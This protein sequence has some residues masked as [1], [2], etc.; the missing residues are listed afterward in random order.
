MF[1]TIAAVLGGTAHADK[2][3]AK[4]VDGK[5]IQEGVGLELGVIV[6]A[7][8]SEY[9]SNNLGIAPNVQGLVI[10][11]RNGV[12]SRMAIGLLVAIA[13]AM[14]QSGPKSVESK[15]YRSGDYIITETKTTYYSEAEKAEMAR[16]TEKSIDGLFSAPYADF[17]LHLYSRDRF[18]RGDTSGYK[19]NM[20]IGSG[21]T[22]AF[23]TGL[24]FG[25][26]TSLVE[27]DGMPTRVR[28]SYLGMPFRVSA[29]AG[30]VRIALTYEWNWLDYGVEG[31]DRQ[32]GMDMDGVAATRTTSHPWHLDMSTLLFKRISLTGGVTTQVLRKYELGFYATAGLF[33]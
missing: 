11:D 6:Q 21:D 32:L 25:G 16:N 12:T 27:H 15:S 9:A 17:E 13:G 3:R 7:G 8:Q 19:L 4:L 28:Y 18:G 29:A 1:L 22:Y 2:K 30:P 10:R 24:G 26:V 20:L 5:A 23:E 31:A 33:F 14:A